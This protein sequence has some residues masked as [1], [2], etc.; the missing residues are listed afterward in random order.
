MAREGYDPVYGARPLKRFLQRELESR[1]A[2][3]LIAGQVTEGSVVRVDAQG[4]QLAV[5]IESPKETP[6]V[7]EVAV[8]A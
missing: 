1:I 2:R 5:N 7:A 4:G 3:A 8:G 6:K